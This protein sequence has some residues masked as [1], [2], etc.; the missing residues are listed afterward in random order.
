MY[1]VVVVGGGM[2]GMS[3]ALILG[4]A[5]RRVLVLDG[6]AP[7]NQVAAHSH[8]LVTRDGAPPLELLAQA[9]RDLAAYP[10]VEVVSAEATGGSGEL[11]DFRLEL[12]NG[13]VV[14]ARRLIMATGVR[15]VLPEIDGLQELWGRGVYHCPFC[16]GWEVRDTTWAVLGDS[17]MAYERLALYRGWASEL[18]LLSNGP[19]SLSEEDRTRI[20]QLGVPIEERS[21]KRLEAVGGEAVSIGFED[22][23][24]MTAGALFVA[25]VVEQR[26]RLPELLGCKVEATAPLGSSFVQVDAVTSETSVAGVY[27]VGDMAGQIQSLIM[28]SASGARAAYQITHVLAL[29][30]TLGAIVA[31]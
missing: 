8:G 3:A 11:G 15:D 24:V 4:R 20:E 12:T 10:N 28:A 19:S 13:E 31:A 18:V 23:S 25:S 22:G 17:P 6:G 21:V 1:D 9:R 16:H 27:G 30:E 7:R 29:E 2:A 14:S 5:R 26:S